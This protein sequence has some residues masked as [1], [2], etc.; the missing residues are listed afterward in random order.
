MVEM[1]SE[2]PSQRLILLDFI[3][4]R[5]IMWVREVSDHE[6]RKGKSI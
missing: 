6:P 3:G 5:S 4:K 1:R 2:S